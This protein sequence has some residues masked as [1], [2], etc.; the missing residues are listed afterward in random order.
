MGIHVFVRRGCHVDARLEYSPAKR[1]RNIRHPCATSAGHEGAGPL[2]RH[3]SVGPRETGGW[4]YSRGAGERE[5]GPEKACQVVQSALVVFS[6]PTRY[7]F[8]PRCFQRMFLRGGWGDGSV[9][10]ILVID[11]CVSLIELVFCIV[12]MCRWRWRMTWSAMAS[13]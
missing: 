9:A 1:P 11:F 6:L 5:M 13:P 7:L 12:P 8:P 10:M 2:A 3:V 4:E